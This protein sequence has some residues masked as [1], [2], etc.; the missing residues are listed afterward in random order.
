[1]T[2]VEQAAAIFKEVNGVR[3][4]FIKRVVAE[5]GMGQAGAST[6]FQNEKKRAAGG[7]VVNYRPKTNKG[8]QDEQ[9]DDSQEDVE[10]FNVLGDDERVYT[11]T[12]QADAD[13]HIAKNGGKLIT[14]E[15]AEAL[16]QA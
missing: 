7:K 10:L 15:E 8:Q 6:Y 1:M 2:K 9:V 11:Y 14:N 4:D 5:L 12:N 16:A 3:A 13:E